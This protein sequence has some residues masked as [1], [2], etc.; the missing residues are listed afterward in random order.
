MK[1]A[2]FKGK[3]FPLTV[4]EF[5]KPR[6]VKDQVLI[7]LKNAALNHRDAVFALDFGTERSATGET[8]KDGRGYADG[9][10]TVLLDPA[11]QRGAG[12]GLFDVHTLVDGGEALGDGFVGIQC[13]MHGKNSS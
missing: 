9:K 6:P 13:E 8:P 11:I 1:A 5:K 2:V 3:D 7:R 10:R 4:E 12:A